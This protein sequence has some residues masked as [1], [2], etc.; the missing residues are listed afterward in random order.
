MPSETFLFQT[1][2]SW[3][4]ADKEERLQYTAQLLDKV[5]LPLVDIMVLLDELESEEFNSKSECF[6]LVH[7]CLLQQVC[8]SLSSPFVQDK[9][10]PR[11]ASKVSAECTGWYMVCCC[12]R[13]VCFATE[14]ST[15]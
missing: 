3:I 10:E 7:M 13:F 2:I 11:V 14:C 4:K 12:C 1:V 5:R 8:P 15:T 9:G 6:Y